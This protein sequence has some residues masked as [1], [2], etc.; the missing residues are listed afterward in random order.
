LEQLRDLAPSIPRSLLLIPG[1]GAPPKETVHSL[2]LTSITA[3]YSSIDA[4]FTEACAKLKVPFRAYTV[5]SP[6]RARELGALGVD[7][8]IS[9]DPRAIRDTSGESSAGK[10]SSPAGA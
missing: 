4:L 8:V 1:A 3:H 6:T 9:D 10:E 2:G 5:N 7:I